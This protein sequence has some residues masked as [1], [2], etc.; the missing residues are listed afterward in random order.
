M[1]LKLLLL[2]VISC[3]YCNQNYAQISV[4]RKKTGVFKDFR[5][6]ELST[7]KK[8]TTVFVIDQLNINEYEKIIK[9]NWTFNDYLIIDR[10][11][12]ENSKEKYY[13]EK[14]AIWILQGEHVTVRKTNSKGMRTGTET[15]YLY[16]YLDYY[17]L[18][19]IKKKDGKVKSSTYNG[20]AA[21]YLGLNSEAGWE[22]IRTHKF[23]DLDNDTYNYKLGYL[24][25]YIQVIN[26]YLSTNWFSSC[27]DSSYDK[28]LI[29]KLKKATLY[30]P[31][32]IKIK[33][34]W[35]YKDTEREDPEK[36]FKNYNYKYEFINDKE[37]N[38]KI[39]ESNKDSEDF[40]YLTFIRV[41]GQ[42]FI[43]VVNGKTGDLLYKDYQT[44]SYSLKAKD[45]AKL[46]RRIKKG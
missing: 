46:N 32:Y 12:Y 18:T 5:K 23:G 24:K 11:V 33:S 3:L 43:S 37:L 31:D 28:R 35:G 44:L 39:L 22:W 42:K 10:E 26:D 9:E 20:I 14:Y 17:Y 16:I 2:L 19:D 30:V 36:L 45:I 29:K 6:G 21:V 7:I 1:K 15:E 38:K 13:D 27:Y 34:N 41:N 40:Y 4:G 25:N 8:K